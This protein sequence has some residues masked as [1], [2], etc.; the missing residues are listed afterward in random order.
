[1][2]ANSTRTIPGYELIRLWESYHYRYTEAIDKYHEA[3]EKR[4]KLR[5]PLKK[6]RKEVIEDY[7]NLPF[8]RMTR[9][10][11]ELFVG[12]LSPKERSILYYE[13]VEMV[14]CNH[15]YNTI[16]N[17][18]I[19]T[20]REEKYHARKRSCNSLGIDP[21]VKICAGSKFGRRRK[22]RLPID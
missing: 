15:S 9:T 14:D 22:N 20:Q 16:V 18:V 10:E 1:M 6:V 11:A 3:V 19:D 17:Y 2:D 7:P 12:S 5:I 8:L 13:I 4:R 21:R